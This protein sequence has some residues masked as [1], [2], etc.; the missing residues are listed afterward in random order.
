MLMYARVV[1]LLP[2]EPAFITDHCED[3]M[4][5][6]PTNPPD[7]F[8]CSI[9]CHPLC[10]S[11]KVSDAVGELFSHEHSYTIRNIESGDVRSALTVSKQNLI[12][13]N[14]TCAEWDGKVLLVVL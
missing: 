7:F 12:H 6:D 11:V 13:W 4:I 1:G 14:V 5:D 2:G 8:L 10:Q 9:Y 3:V